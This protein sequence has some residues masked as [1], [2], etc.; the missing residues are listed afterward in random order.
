MGKTQYIYGG[1]YVTP[2]N[3]EELIPTRVTGGLKDGDWTV[4]VTKT[5]VGGAFPYELSITL[6]AANSAA[7]A[8]LDGKNLDLLWGTG[9]CGNDTIFAEYNR[10]VKTPEPASIALLAGGLLAL[11][12][13]RK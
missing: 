2:I 1:K 10:P 9:D 4:A 8:L 3:T 5:N 7:F 6:T 12:R 11:R 13:K